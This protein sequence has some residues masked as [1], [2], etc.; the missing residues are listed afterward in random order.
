[1]LY[2]L[3]FHIEY[4]ETMSQKELFAVWSRE[5]AVALEAKK[6]GVIVVTTPVRGGCFL[7]L[8]D[9]GGARQTMPS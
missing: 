9:R 7:Y 5:A 3:D 6:K 4:P 2:M 1:M 8:W